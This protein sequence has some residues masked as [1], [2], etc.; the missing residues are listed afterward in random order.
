[1][2]R[3]RVCSEPAEVKDLWLHLLG[4]LLVLVIEIANSLE[5]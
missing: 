5:K 2:G 4:T 1:M 3:L